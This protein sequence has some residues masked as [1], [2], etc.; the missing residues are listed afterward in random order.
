MTTAHD[1]HEPLDAEERDLAARLARTGPLDGPPP[2]LDA[3][4]LAAAH[5]A[6]ATRTRGRR[7]LAWLGVP[8]ALVTGMGVAAAAVLALGL[9]W[10]LRPQYSGVT[11]HGDAG[12]EEVI[13]V[14]EPAA[15]APAASTKAPPAEKSLA[16]AAPQRSRRAA[17]ATLESVPQPREDTAK[18]VAAS[19]AAA[20]A[21]AAEE[22]AAQAMAFAEERREA[23]SAAR[24]AA[25]SGFVAEPPAAPAPAAAAPAV[26]RKTRATYTTA[27]RREQAAN[28]APA[29]A[30]AAPPPPAP[31]AAAADAE[32]QTLDRIEV[33]GS[34]IKQ[35]GDIDWAGI[36]VSDDSRLAAPEWLERIRARRDDGD[37]DNAR[38]SLRLF[39][40]KHPRVHLPD[41]LRALLAETRR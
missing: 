5:A 40:R 34:R 41:D 26:E 12:E 10:Q 4:I 9:V 28:A 1:H 27:E 15:T 25:E 35:N 14:A 19:A 20:D 2:A 16:G 36:P 22:A 37:T 39:Q 7:H 18:A 8:P 13:L 31:V 38:A 30:A 32:P 11:A 23:D 3:K 17:P 29:A 33:T 21:A 24:A 6:A